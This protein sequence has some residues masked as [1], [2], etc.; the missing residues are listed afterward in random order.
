MDSFW[1]QKKDLNVQAIGYSIIKS[2][3]GDPGDG[4]LEG[5]Y[6]L[7]PFDI[8]NEPRNTTIDEIEYGLKALDIVS[9][10]AWFK[11]ND[12]K[13]INDTRKVI[14]R[15]IMETINESILEYPNDPQFELKD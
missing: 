6:G 7:L 13:G 12:M 9:K 11:Q 10:N 4:T 14:A 2:W 15:Y 5:L 8:N 3:Y 1:L